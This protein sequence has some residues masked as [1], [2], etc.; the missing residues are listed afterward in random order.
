MRS[1]LD[2]RSKMAAMG[3]Q[4]AGKGTENLSHYPGAEMYFM[5]I[6]NI[7]AARE[8]MENMV[9]V[10]ASRSDHLVTPTLLTSIRATTTTGSS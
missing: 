6:A 3:N 10:V 9:Y 1:I 2:A 7:H 8:S 5:N 4:A